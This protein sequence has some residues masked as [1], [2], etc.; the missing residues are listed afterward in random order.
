MVENKMSVLLYLLNKHWCSA[1]LRVVPGKSCTTR[2]VV[3]RSAISEY[4]VDT[5]YFSK[6]QIVKPLW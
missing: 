4:W 3:L 6:K 5:F 1:T 2:R